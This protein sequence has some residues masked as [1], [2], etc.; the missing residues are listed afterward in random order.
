M[1]QAVFFEL[2]GTL[3]DVETKEGDLP[4]YERLAEWLADRKI[5]SNPTA[6]RK[7]YLDGVEKAK[8]ALNDPE[9]DIDVLVVFQGMLHELGVAKPTAT[10]VNDL[11]QAFRRFT[12]SKL[13][14]VLGANDL[15]QKLRPDYRLG[16]IA[17]GQKMFTRP[18]LEELRMLEPFEAITLSSEVGFK[19]PSQKLFE[20]GLQALEVT[21][22]EA[23]YV[24]SQYAEDIAGAKALGVKCIHYSP[25]G[26]FGTTNQSDA[27]VKRMS[28]VAKHLEQWHEP[29]ESDIVDDTLDED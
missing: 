24:G 17:N 26:N 7:S 2:Y 23:V 6:L 3:V 5:R 11:G 18:E 15:L 27:K 8:A 9:G 22:D 29:L 10:M 12:R 25:S 4:P 21:P 14:P 20:V 28:E 16:I 1:I 13:A 19:K